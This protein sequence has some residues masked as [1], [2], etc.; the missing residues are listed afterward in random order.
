MSRDDPVIGIYWERA[1]W[2]RAR[3]AY[4]ADLDL[5]P[6]GPDAFVGWLELAVE[7]HTRR[8][9]TQRAELAESAAIE[10]ATSG[11]NFNKA[12]HL[13]Q[14]TI[15]AMEDAIVDDRQQL[16]RMVG[17]SEF[18]RAAASAAAAQTE[19]DYGRALP[20]PPARLPTRPVRRR[21]RS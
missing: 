3:S 5:D 11:K 19:R 12:H 16:G 4:V 13:R 7:R 20:A 18:V 8:T 9:P 17:R 15:D 14:A 2:D 1:V 6:D 10:P 21:A